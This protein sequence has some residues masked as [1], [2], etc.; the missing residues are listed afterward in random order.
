MLAAADIRATFF[1]Q[2]RWVMAQPDLA[3]QIV[4]IRSLADL[5]DLVSGPIRPGNPLKYAAY[6]ALNNGA[7]S[8]GLLTSVADPNDRDEWKKVTDMISE[9]DDVFHVFPLT[10]GDRDINELFYQH[11]KEM[12]QVEAAKERVLY[13][14]AHDPETVAILTS[15]QSRPVVGKLS[16]ETSVGSSQYA[17]YTVETSGVDFLA[18]GVKTGDTLRTRFDFDLAG[19]EVWT[20]YQVDEVVNAATLRLTAESATIVPDQVA[21][22]FEIWRTQNNDDYADSIAATGGF[23]DMLVRYLYIDNADQEFSPLGPAAALVGLIGSVVPHQG[24]TWYPL[25]G[26]E[27]DGWT[28]RFSNAQLNH[29]A[30]NGVLLITKHADGY[31]CARHAVTTYKSPL[32]ADPRTALT[33]KMTEEMFVRNGL[34]VKKEY[35]C[36]LRGFNGIANNSP[37]TRLA[38]LA[39]L[40]MKSDQLKNDT[41]Y[42]TLGGRIT[43]GPFDL[44]IRTHALFKDHV[45]VSLRVEGPV[46]LN[47]LECDLFI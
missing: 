10:G 3:R 28:N 23:D 35:R 31:L 18:L 26:F 8:Q 21:M 13:L 32:D 46:P 14:V 17:A 25:E 5:N 30:G 40:N 39:N 27:T 19:R 16:V 2:G 37:G 11:I 24:V 36:A 12:N 44:D 6:W 20:E 7:G 29:M 43:A 34:L 45:L 15:D 42:P 9:R 33:M 1:L 41:E 22:S 4:T 47:S 38:I